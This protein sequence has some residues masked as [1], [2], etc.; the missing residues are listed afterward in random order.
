MAEPP[1]DARIYTPEV[2]KEGNALLAK[3]GESGEYKLGLSLIK[4]L[5]LE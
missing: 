1:L 3:I 2:L 5:F 4:R